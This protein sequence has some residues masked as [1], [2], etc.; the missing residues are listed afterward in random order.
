MIGAGLDKDCRPF[1]Q[2][3]L[4]ALDLEDAPALEDDVQLVVIVRLLSV[5]FR[6][7]EAVDTDFEAGGL[8]DDL[9]P[10]AG[11]TEPLLDSCDFECV[12]VA[13]LLHLHRQA[14]H[15]VLADRLHRP[16]P[17]IVLAGPGRETVEALLRQLHRR[18]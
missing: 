17:G 15:I 4:L 13:N 12:H 8:V 6:G 2:G 18:R 5:G 14:E 7:Y 3:N 10:T 1:V 11:L 16:G 9:V